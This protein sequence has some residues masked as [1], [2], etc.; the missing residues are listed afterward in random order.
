MTLLRR[1]SVAGSCRISADDDFFSGGALLADIDAGSKHSVHFHALQIEISY[2]SVRSVG[3]DSLQ[4]GNH[5]VVVE[6]DIG[7]TGCR[8]K[9]KMILVSLHETCGTVFS[10]NALL[11]GLCANRVL[12]YQE[13]IYGCNRHIDDGISVVVITAEN[14]HFREIYG[15]AVDVDVGGQFPGPVMIVAEIAAVVMLAPVLEGIE[16][17][18]GVGHPGDD[19][20]GLMHKLSPSGTMIVLGPSVGSSLEIGIPG[21]GRV[22]VDGDIHVSSHRKFFRGGII[23]DGIELLVVV[24]LLYGGSTKLAGD[25]KRRGGILGVERK[26]GRSFLMSVHTSVLLPL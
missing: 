8:E 26:L 16:A 24:G 15:P 25:V 9:F 14:I 20:V 1:N 17:R 18:L 10:G 5:A 19:G 23:A 22:V 3:R 6:R 11:H 2:R 13:R 4:P 12:V 7:R 21:I